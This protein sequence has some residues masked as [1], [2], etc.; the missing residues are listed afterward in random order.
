MEFITWSE[1]ASCSGALVMVLIITQITKEVKFIK[2]IPTQL[3]S[4][5]VSLIILY[6]AYFFTQQLTASSA[7]LIPF[8]AAVV[9]LS[10]NGGFDALV[11]AFPSIFNKK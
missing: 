8:N 6:L 10:A 9:A 3:W 4:Y 5:I 7:V 2:A 11:K 1:L